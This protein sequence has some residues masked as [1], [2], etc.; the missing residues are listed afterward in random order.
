MIKLLIPTLFYLLTSASLYGQIINIKKITVSR[1]ITKIEND[2]R[3]EGMTEGPN[4]YFELEIE[5]NTDSIIKLETSQSE[6]DILFRYKGKSYR[7]KAFGF[8]LIP[9]Y[10]KK[11]IQ[12]KPNEKYPVKFSNSILL[13]TRLL[14]YNN[15]SYNYYD[16]SEEILQILPTLQVQYVDQKIKI[17]SCKIENVDVENYIYI[18]K[19]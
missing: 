15:S 3:E 14:K 8:S 1:V 10:E 16:Y 5:N 11:E 9:F 18:P 6:F 2:V 7:N 12:I 17:V 13:G 4:V 19:L